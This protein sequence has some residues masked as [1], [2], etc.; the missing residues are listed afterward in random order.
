MKASDTLQDLE[1]VGLL[2]AVAYLIYWIASGK[3]A[4][5]LGPGLTSLLPKQTSALNVAPGTEQ[6][7]GQEI[8]GATPSGTPYAVQP[9]GTITVM[10]ESGPQ[11]FGS[12]AEVPGTG[13]TVA[14]LQESG[15]SNNKI[16]A[17]LQQFPTMDAY[18]AAIGLPAGGAGG[19]W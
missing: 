2:G 4:T 6:T 1:S 18:N 13:Q 12:S 10:L 7:V 3:A 11:E 17:M 15:V 14:E 16:A 9:T 8:F 19:S 5:F